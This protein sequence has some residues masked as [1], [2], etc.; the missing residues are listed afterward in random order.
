MIKIIIATVIGVL[1]G[2][3][4]TYIFL[5]DLKEHTDDLAV[6][7]QYK[8]LNSYLLT[9]GTY[10]A[11]K[12]QHETY[13]SYLE[14]YEPN[15][16]S[17]I[18]TDDALNMEKAVTL[19]RLAKLEKTNSNIETY[20]NFLNNAVE[21]CEKFSSVDKNCTISMLESL[22]CIFNMTDKD[23]DCTPNKSLNQAGANNAPPG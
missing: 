4:G 21:A 18:P 23:L 15:K 3:T 20:N 2:V 8:Y 17:T 10:E 14:T 12:S 1:L 9:N 22:S 19:Y 11:I 16:Y 5:T 7:V 6:Q 13:L